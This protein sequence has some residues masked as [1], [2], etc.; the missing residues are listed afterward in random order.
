[1]RD[2]ANDTFMAL[3][4]KFDKR[5]PDLKSKKGNGPHYWLTHCLWE[6]CHS[7]D[8]VRKTNRL[9]LIQL[10]IAEGHIILPELADVLLDEVRAWVKDAG[11]AR[12][13]T[14]KHK[15]TITRDSARRWWVRR[16]NELIEGASAPS[17]GKL[18]E[19]MREAGLPDDLIGLAIEM[20]LDYSAAA[21]TSR[22]MEPEDWYRLQGRVKSE[23]ASLRARLVSG[24][25]D[26]APAEFHALCLER[27]DV[28]STIGAV[29][30]EE[31]SAIRKGCM[32][33]I[34]DRC[35]LRF[36][37]PSP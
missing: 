15:K 9:H 26:L 2:P 16:R 29:A 27:M 21:R 12:W 20:R 5:F 32:Y 4:S 14:D 6:E 11:S 22:Y 34:A 1:M 7:E 24:Q 33:D 8:A 25:L 37:R 17:G 19:K 10:S 13:L 31:Y 23:V 18:A 36:T 30:G 3:R 28:P 35:L